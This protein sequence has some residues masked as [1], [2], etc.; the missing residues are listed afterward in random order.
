MFLANKQHTEKRNNVAKPMYSLLALKYKLVDKIEPY[1]KIYKPTN[2]LNNG[3]TKLYLDRDIVT[4][5]TT[6][7]NR[8]NITLQIKKHKL[9]I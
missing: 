5:K 4:D 6:E 7:N 2:V 1:Y 9:L 8:P 3:N